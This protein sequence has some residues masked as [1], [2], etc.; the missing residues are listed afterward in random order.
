VGE[1]EKEEKKKKKK[2]RLK[3]SC[4]R[5]VG[6]IYAFS[7]SEQNKC[8]HVRKGKKIKEMYVLRKVQR[9]EM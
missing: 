9:K 7:R 1:K 6:G 2:D 3:T 8:E 4:F 5:E